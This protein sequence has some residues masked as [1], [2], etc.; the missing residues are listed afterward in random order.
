MTKIEKHFNNKTCWITGGG[1]GIGKSIALQ[2]ANLGAKVIVSGRSADKL[3]NVKSI[4]SE[5]NTIQLDVTSL[6]SW[7]KA[8]EQIKA[9]NLSPDLVIYN[10]GACKYIDLPDFPPEVFEEIMNV[11]YMGIINGIH[12][13]IPHMLEKNEGH[14]VAVTSSVARLP[15]PRAEA[16]GA[17]K[18]AATYL[19][20]SLRIGLTETNLKITTVMP[21]FVSTPMTDRNDFPMPFIIS[22]DAAATRILKGILKGKKDIF[23]PS[24]FTWPL[25]FIASLPTYLG[26][27]FT[28]RLKK[29]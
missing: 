10:A 12:T 23:F 28:R 18:A 14:L 9:D 24:R 3:A 20:D 11:N 25:R 2:L 17:S 6:D 19:M 4:N 16:Y 26:Y 22:P 13:I 29:T 5:I 7:Q 1:S 8:Y 27:Q 15:L 21:G